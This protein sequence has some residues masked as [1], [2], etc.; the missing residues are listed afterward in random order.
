MT[1]VKG[2]E[3]GALG[4]AG[5][6]LD[7][8]PGVKLGGHGRALLLG[9]E[10]LAVGFAV[11]QAAGEVQAQAVGDGHGLFRGHFGDQQGAE[12][13]DVGRGGGFAAQ[14]Q[15]VVGGELPGLA[16][17]AEAVAA[18]DLQRAKARV[19]L[20]QEEAGVDQWVVALEALAG[21]G[22]GLD[23]GG[24][25]GQQA[26]GLLGGAGDLFFNVA[27][28]LFGVLG[29]GL[30]ALF[31]V[32][33]PGLQFGIAQRGLGQGG[34]LLGCLAAGHDLL[35][36]ELSGCFPESALLGAADLAGG[37]L[38]RNFGRNGDTCH[39]GDGLEGLGLE[40]PCSFWR[41]CRCKG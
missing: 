21:G 16:F 4:V 29:N 41:K 20:A 34:G 39:N 33:A 19:D 32:G 10:A 40:R 30:Q 24:P 23:L 18:P 26:Q 17:G 12:F 27:E 28:V 36:E 15:G 25:L 8:F 14:A 13:L 1:R 6:L 7:G 22:V 37:F 11:E 9:F 3:G 38:G 2:W 35:G 5:Q 31:Q